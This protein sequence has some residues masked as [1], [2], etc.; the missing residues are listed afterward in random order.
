MLMRCLD[1]VGEQCSIMEYRGFKLIYRR[2]ASL[3]FI[4]GVDHEEVRCRSRP[5]LA[6]L[7]AGVRM[8]AHLLW[9]AE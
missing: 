3:F 4:V 8:R 6:S 5:C 1:A 9:C 7:L 2:Y